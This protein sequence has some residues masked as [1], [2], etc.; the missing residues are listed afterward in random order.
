MLELSSIGGGEGGLGDLAALGGDFAA[1]GALPAVPGDGAA[2]PFK[3]FFDS[4]PEDQRGPMMALF[5]KTFPAFLA[6][7]MEEQQMQAENEL[8]RHAVAKGALGGGS[9]ASG[10]GTRRRR[11]R[12]R[13]RRRSTPTPS[14][15]LARGGTARRWRR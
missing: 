14:P 7:E 11:R 10:R 12:A 8:F 2:N 13:R 5:E 4:M 3:E 9:G 15:R 1:L 6:Q